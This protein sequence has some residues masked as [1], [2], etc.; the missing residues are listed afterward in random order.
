MASP[1]GNI[2]LTGMSVYTMKGSDKIII[3]KKGG[4]KPEQVLK[5][6]SFERSRE[7]ATEFKG[8]NMAVSAIRIPLL[9]VNHLADHNFTSTLTKICKKIQ[10]L[11]NTGD[12]GQRC[13]FLSQGRY[14]LAGFRL[15][16][17]HPFTSILAEPVHCTLNRETKSAVIQLPRLVPGINLHLPWKQPY[18]R[19]SLSLGLVPDVIYENGE[20]HYHV[21]GRDEKSLDT[22]W[23]VVT[24]T[25]QSQTLEL[26]LNKPDAINDAQTMIF[27]IGIEMGMPGPNGEITEVK[28]GGSACILAVG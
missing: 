24:D 20:Y 22:T 25:F 2:I 23:Q 27:A 12:R 17:K 15:N 3:R 11:D 4:P 21:A 19:F 13:V 18:Y 10:L 1:K 9:D 8:V 5:A 7:N 16:N 6:K 14:M 28:Y 26:K